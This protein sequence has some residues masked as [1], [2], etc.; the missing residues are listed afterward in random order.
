[1]ELDDPPRPAWSTATPAR[2]SCTGNRGA[3][4]TTSAW[5]MLTSPNLRNAPLTDGGG[6]TTAVA[7][8]P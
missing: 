2:C 4:A 1:M 5:A 6:S 7:G 3:G 8:A